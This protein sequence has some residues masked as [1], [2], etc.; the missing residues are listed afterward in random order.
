M[1]LPFILGLV[2]G[3]GVVY[4][5]NNREEL[6]EQLKARSKD[7]KSGLKKGQEALGKVRGRAK[8]LAQSLV[9]DESTQ[10]TKGKRKR[11]TKATT[12]KATKSTAPKTTRR[13]RVAKAPSATET[14]VATE[15]TLI[16][17][18]SN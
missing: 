17:S 14:A 15:A 6:Q 18:S 9:A 3:G 1:A 4:A 12:A 13:R 11:A 10:S 7:L 5:Y 8:N 16:P 2:I